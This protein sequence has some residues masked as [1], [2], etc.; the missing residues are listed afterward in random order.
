MIYQFYSPIPQNL[1][2]SALFTYFSAM[3]NQAIYSVELKKSFFYDILFTSRGGLLP[4]C[5]IF[6]QAVPLVDTPMQ[7]RPLSQRS[8]RNARG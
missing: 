3:Y 7:P 5:K 1:D 6:C 4:E 8:Y 2:K